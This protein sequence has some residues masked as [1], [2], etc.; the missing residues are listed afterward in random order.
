MST[1]EYEQ[2]P[3]GSSRRRRPGRR[4]TPP[5][6]D[7]VDA[8]LLAAIRDAKGRT[9][10]DAK[11]AGAVIK[12]LVERIR[13]LNPQTAKYV[14]GIL[15]TLVGAEIVLMEQSEIDPIKEREIYQEYLLRIGARKIPRGGH[16]PNALDTQRQLLIQFLEHH[17]APLDETHTEDT[18]LWVEANWQQIVDFIGWVPCLCTSSNTF[19]P[20]ALRKIPL[21]EGTLG[22][23]RA[24]LAYFHNTTPEQIKKLLKQSEKILFRDHLRTK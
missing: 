15:Q 24:L 9:P 1:D 11:L 22:L 16:M 20:L 18:W 7:I 5:H 21:A 3:S 4:P 23:V 19:D 12:M 6:F 8:R 13:V 10:R 14:E 2:R 17:P